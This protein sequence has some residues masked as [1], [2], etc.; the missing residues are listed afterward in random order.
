MAPEHRLS[1]K[2][3]SDE[4]RLEGTKAASSVLQL[5]QALDEIPAIDILD[6]SDELLRHKYQVS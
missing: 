5:L 3:K 4:L 6:E 2:L 1:L